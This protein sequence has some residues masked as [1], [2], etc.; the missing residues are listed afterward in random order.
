MSQ[1]LIDH[2]EIRAWVSARAGTPAIISMP[3]GT[4][5]TD[6]RLRLVFGQRAINAEGGEGPDR[7]GGIESVTWTEWFDL[8]ENDGLALLVPDDTDNM[9]ESAYTLEKRP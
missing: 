4:G 1:T 7:L 8:F 3:D 5:D 6:D 9:E 2:D